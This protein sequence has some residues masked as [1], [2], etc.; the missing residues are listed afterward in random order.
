MPEEGEVEEEQTI[1]L[2]SPEL[3][4]EIE[5]SLTKGQALYITSVLDAVAQPRG[6]QMVEFVYD[7]MNRL[8]STTDSLIE[9]S[10]TT[11]EAAP[12]PSINRPEKVKSAIEVETKTELPQVAQVFNDNVL[13]SED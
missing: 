1:N 13:V 11:E 3:M 7:L 6:F 5:I 10:E 9:E 2:F 8:K 4:E 12:T